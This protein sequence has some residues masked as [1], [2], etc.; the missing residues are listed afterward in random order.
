MAM[1]FG[2]RMRAKNIRIMIEEQAGQRRYIFTEMPRA[3]RDEEMSAL[4]KNI[5]QECRA[6]AD[7]IQTVDNEMLRKRM[8]EAAD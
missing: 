1:Q 3:L 4:Y 6:F 8:G 2:K 7:H 5:E